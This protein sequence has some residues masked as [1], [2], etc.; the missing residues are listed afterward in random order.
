MFEMIID[1][2]IHFELPEF[3][4]ELFESMKCEI[5]DLIQLVINTNFVFDEEP[6][7]SNLYYNWVLD[8][9][10]L[11]QKRALIPEI[12]RCDHQNIDGANNDIPDDI[13]AEIRYAFDV[14]RNFEG[15][16]F[17]NMD[18]IRDQGDMS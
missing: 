11:I 2:L 3:K 4:K 15:V 5:L 17:R 6:A 8:R 12:E 16:D 13:K 14:V 9:A 7:P 18:W 1:D 10:T